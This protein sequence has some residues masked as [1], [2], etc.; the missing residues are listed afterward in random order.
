MR[1]Q[2]EQM[3][4]DR[5]RSWLGQAPASSQWPRRQ[6]TK[7]QLATQSGGGMRGETSKISLPDVRQRRGLAQDSQ[8]YGHGRL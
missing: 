6:L 7:P 1:L 2:P 3:R 5:R 4:Q 8:D